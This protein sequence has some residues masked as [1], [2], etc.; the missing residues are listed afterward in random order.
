MQEEI[1]L[2]KYRTGT[3][4]TYFDTN[5]SEYNYSTSTTPAVL[6]LNSLEEPFQLFIA[7][8]FQ[9]N[10]TIT[11]SENLEIWS[12]SGIDNIQRLQSI[13]P[14]G[15]MITGRTFSIN[16]E[17]NYT[18]YNSLK[19]GFRNS[20]DKLFSGQSKSF[21]F[22]H[23][24][25]MD[26]F[27]VNINLERTFDVLNTLNTYNKVYNQFPKRS[28]KTGVIFGKLEA[29]QKIKDEEGNF[30]KIPLRGVPVTIFNSSERFKTTSSISNSGERIRM[31]FKE[32][33]NIND[34]DPE[35]PEENFY[36]NRQS[37][38]LDKNIL[39]DKKKYLFNGDETKT[40]N[41]IFPEEFK[42]STTTNEN[43]EFLIQDVPVG[44]QVLMF[45][46][47]LLQQ[48]LSK[49]EVALN[50]FPYRNE[51][52]SN[53]DEVPHYFFR[54]I[55]VDI[56][57]SWGTSQS[58]YTEVNVTANLDL[59]KWTTYFFSPVG[60]K[61]QGVKDVFFNDDALPQ[62]KH[63]RDSGQKILDHSNYFNNN[64]WEFHPREDVFFKLGD[65]Y[66]TSHNPTPMSIK[67]RD[68]TKLNEDEGLQGSINDV[69][70][71][72]I[73]MV[74]IDNIMNRASLGMYEWNNEF[75]Q[76]KDVAEFRTYGY[77][78]IKLPANLYDFENYKTD[79]KGEPYTNNPYQKGVWLSA[80]QFKMFHFFPDDSYRT[81][82]Y[83]YKSGNKSSRDFYH[84][85]VGTPSD[86]LSSRELSSRAERNYS[87]PFEKSWT[88]NYPNKYSIP[89]LP[90][91]WAG[92]KTE[93]NDDGDDM[94]V[95]GVPQYYDGYKLKL[96]G[97]YGSQY[98]T[99]P[100]GLGGLGLAYFGYNSEEMHNNDTINRLEINSFDLSSLDPNSE[101]NSAMK[102][103]TFN[104]SI[105]T[106]SLYLYEYAPSKHYGM[107]ANG[108]VQNETTYNNGHINK[109]TNVSN[110]LNGEQYQ[111]VEC[112]FGY[113]L[114][115]SGM[116][117]IG[118]NWDY[119]F[120]CKYHSNYA[121]TGQQFSAWQ[122]FKDDN[123]YYNK[124][125][126]IHSV[127]FDGG[128]TQAL[129]LDYDNRENR[130]NLSNQGAISLYRLSSNIFK[131][132][133]LIFNSL[134]KPSPTLYKATIYIQQVRIQNENRNNGVSHCKDSNKKRDFE[135]MS[136]TSNY[137]S[138][139]ITITNKGIR[140]AII[141]INGVEKKAFLNSPVVFTIDEIG[142][143][144]N[145]SIKLESNDGHIPDPDGEDYST[146]SKFDYT[147]KFDGISDVSNN[148]NTY[149]V[150]LNTT[151][152]ESHPISSIKNYYIYQDIHNV[153]TEYRKN[154][155]FQ[156]STCSRTNMKKMN[157][158]VNGMYYV[159]S[160][161]T[162]QQKIRLTTGPIGTTCDNNQ[163]YYVTSY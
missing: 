151:V 89:K 5:I 10:E 39:L 127:F 74:E 1:L 126:N 82:G 123:F 121:G 44:A 143:W 118:F 98:P 132:P 62:L 51:E 86:P 26:D 147:I 146:Y 130:R 80:Y 58:G 19:T 63:L 71:T 35:W 76:I 25:L 90:T 108:Y 70:N 155:L 79:S 104:S 4:V 101:N 54:K 56:V 8:E 120:Q 157:I 133:N 115:P 24:A 32:N 6:Y 49:E 47:D 28:A 57:P 135:I 109:P 150:D 59:R 144:H 117:Q 142:T 34:V 21:T 122:G 112:G 43:G 99:T 140:N 138:P 23:N 77:H 160:P 87:F 64:Q 88:I 102:G 18:N 61:L 73:Q 52:V 162:Y 111:R 128:M 129:V 69:S 42:Y 114:M 153:K 2:K 124:S 11:T 84:L 149:T 100:L 68:M 103:N 3:T 106:E 45:E 31:C 12:V 55:P 154:T 158:R 16:I 78:A 14:G 22:A 134:K 83:E 48:G 15:S 119:D 94:V 30:I 156:N 40:R 93:T 110:V 36:A 107:Y 92:T 72:R 139:T 116:P 9:S 37:Y 65:P 13:P 97:G 66:L 27:E 50:F 67:V 113:Y 163:G 29:R 145:G 96:G 75:S 7:S 46:V 95:I 137:G 53:I 148:N 161:N 17:K 38:D 141:K 81:T 105:S 33:K 41:L 159:K 91:D 20:M 131:D 136:H 125:T 152:P 60:A 85:N